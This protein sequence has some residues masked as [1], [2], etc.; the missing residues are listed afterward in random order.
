MH[1]DLN[2]REELFED[3]DQVCGAAPGPRPAVS[4]LLVPVAYNKGYGTVKNK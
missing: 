4:P 1:Y 3:S 2:E